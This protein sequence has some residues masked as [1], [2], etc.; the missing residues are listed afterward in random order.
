MTGYGIVG[1]GVDAETPEWKKVFI[2]SSVT[3]CVTIS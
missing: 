2:G 1:Y 3:D